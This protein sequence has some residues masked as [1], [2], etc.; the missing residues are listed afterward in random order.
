MYCTL[1]MYSKKGTG[2]RL[3][4]PRVRHAKLIH[5]DASAVADLSLRSLS[6]FQLSSHTLVHDYVGH[7]SRHQDSATNV[8]AIAFVQLHIILGQLAAPQLARNQRLS[9][10]WS[11]PGA[12]AIPR[13]WGRQEKNQ[14]IHRWRA[15]RRTSQH[16]ARR[17]DAPSEDLVMSPILFQQ[18][19]WVHGTTDQHPG[20]LAMPHNPGHHLRRWHQRH[21]LIWLCYILVCTSGVL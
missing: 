20:A 6:N 15:L 13:T 9:C 7:L 21:A 17:T 11:T 2:D 3:L 8:L 4:S 10:L 5:R 18:E 12:T 14:T 19:R 1:C 16:R